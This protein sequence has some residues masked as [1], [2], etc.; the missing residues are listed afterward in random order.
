M[1]AWQP[2]CL[3]LLAG[4]GGV[5]PAVP[6]WGSLEQRFCGH[7]CV[8]L[9]WE[10]P[11]DR[12]RRVVGVHLHGMLLLVE[13]VACRCLLPGEVRNNAGHMCWWMLLCQPC[14]LAMRAASCCPRS[15][16]WHECVPCCQHR[17]TRNT[18]WFA[19]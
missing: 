7:V 2:R 18:L 6:A 3:P 17:N 16:L 4:D 8:A 14:L 1:G 10:V 5:G 11:A 13:W 9:R 15:V 19:G 12:C